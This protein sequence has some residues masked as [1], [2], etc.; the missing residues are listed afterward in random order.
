MRYTG[1]R[2]QYIQMMSVFPMLFVSVSILL[3][4]LFAL[5]SWRQKKK[6]QFLP[7]G[8]AP[9]PLLGNPKY[10]G[11]HAVCKH[12]PELW[13]K[14]G[15]VFTI[16]KSTDPVVVL[17][18]YEVVKDALLTHGEEFSGRPFFPVV[19]VYSEGYSFPSL[20]GERWR[21]LRRFTVASLKNLGMGKKP[22]EKWILEESERLIKAMSLTGGKAISA[23][24]LLGCAVGNITIYALL[25]EHFD[26]G[27]AK[28]QELIITTRKFIYDT[29]SPLHELGNTFPVLLNVPILKDKIF[30]ESSQL[31][32]FVRKYIEQHKESLNPSAPRDFTDYF[33][34]KIKEEEN[35]PGSHFTDTSLLMTLIALLAAGTETTTTTLNFCLFLMSNYPDVQ[36]K[37]QQEIDEVTGSQRPAGIMDRPQMPYTNA[38]LH[39]AQRVMD[40]A[41]MATYHAVTKKTTFK[42]YTLPK[43]TTVIPFISSVLNDP[44]QW[45]TPEE[46]NPG[47]FLDDYGQFRLRPAF[48]AFSAG[49]RICAGENLARMELFL[50][51]SA[52][53]QKFT[54]TLPPGAERQDC[55]QLKQNKIR[56]LFFSQVCAEPRPVSDTR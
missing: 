18:G 1:S 9:L 8:P 50:L 31:I 34:I 32:S 38:V 43:G 19:D 47:H 55:R 51:F 4:L 30:K 37:V 3:T 46:F 20:N 2:C 44:T 41:P 54:F 22:M 21:Q 23:L 13:K 24:H 15:P 52:L 5:T 14:Y 33:L 53:L 56:S 40:L 25:G 6:Y 42:G 26:Y 49:K 35:I 39:E 11:E 7:P 16:W 45:E 36:A 10:I 28:F 48:M 27:D 12:I 29:H 17:C